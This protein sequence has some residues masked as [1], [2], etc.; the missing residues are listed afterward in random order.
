MDL[1]V[2]Q[3]LIHFADAFDKYSFDFA[4]T[5]AE[6]LIM[7]IKFILRVCTN[8]QPKLALKEP[9]HHSALQMQQEIGSA[10]TNKEKIAA[11]LA[12]NKRKTNTDTKCFDKTLSLFEKGFGENPV[13]KKPSDNDQSDEA[14]ST[15]AFI[16]VASSC[17]PSIVKD[18]GD[19]ITLN[20]TDLLQKFI[21]IHK[22]NKGK[23]NK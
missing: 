1:F 2:H 9:M 15:S 23:R 6:R 21:S 18:N 20:V 11:V 13:I 14:K 7:F 10:G 22:K 8:R 17:Y 19:S 5:E 3:I 16:R 12:G 4:S